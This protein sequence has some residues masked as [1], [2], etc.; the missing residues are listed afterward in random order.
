[1]TQHHPWCKQTAQPYEGCQHCAFLS[2]AYPLRPGESAAEATSRYFPPAAEPEKASPTTSE[3]IM[4]K[5]GRT[6]LEAS[7]EMIEAH[8]KVQDAL[9]EIDILLRERTVRLRHTRKEAE[10]E[11]VGSARASI[12]TTATRRTSRV[13]LETGKQRH[14]VKR[15]KTTASKLE[16]DGRLPRDLAKHLYA[17]AQQVADGMGASTDDFDDST[18]RLTAP[19]EPVATLGGYGS[20]TP[21]D[22]Q[23]IGLRALQAMKTRIPAELMPIF[24]QIVDEEVAGYSPLARTLAELGE[25]LGYKHKQTTA[26][27]GTLVY[28]VTCLIAHYMRANRLLADALPRP[29]VQIDEP[30]VPGD[31][32]SLFDTKTTKLGN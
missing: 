1:M 27:G 11:R 9:D 31:S 4:I 25:A 30:V 18:N 5:P 8:V 26:A 32:R 13:I 16:K 7:E 21:S 20:R 17:F 10:A 14:E 24:N 19:Y 12:V 3:L 15:V 6:V 28:A 22:R 2:T 23:L 29:Q